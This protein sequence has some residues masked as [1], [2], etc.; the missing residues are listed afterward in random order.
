MEIYK[1]KELKVLI[2]GMG[3]AL[4]DTLGYIENRFEIFGLSDSD[5]SKAENE[6]CK[7]Y[8]FF[9]P[10]EIPVE[11]IDYIVVNS[12]YEDEIC[13]FLVN[14]IEISPEKILKKDIWQRMLFEVSYGSAN[15]DKTFYVMSK[16]I[17]KR[18][19]LLSI[20]FSFLEQ[21]DF[22]DRNGY[23]PVV[24]MQSFPSQYIE[25]EKIGIENAW[26]YYYE[27]L[28]EYTVKDVMESEN[29]ILGYDDPCYQI[30][31]EE[32]Y[33]L[34]RMAELYKKY[35]HIKSNV[36]KDLEKENKDILAVK[37]STLGVLYRGT[38]MVSLKLK[39]HPIQPSIEEL[40]NI[41]KQYMVD[42]KFSHI[43]LST[44]DIDAV[45]R[46]KEEFGQSLLYT[47]QLR[48]T[49][50]GSKWLADLQ[51]NRQSDRYLRGVEYLT[52]IELLSRCNSMVAG[53]SAGSVC[54]LI[55]NDFKYEHYELLDKGSY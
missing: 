13:D 15:S 28:S 23:I 29:V 47:N 52:T 14:E 51:N 19:G 39:K 41:V 33:D 30:N 10:K 17:R 48:Y 55:M 38:D 36:L 8:K 24:D 16:Q 53:V 27:P 50:T 44:E 32:Q 22:V 7:K 43:F 49:N 21:L 40:I 18:N 46:F 31:V 1:I 37:E 5:M 12:V 42:Y 35:I 45:E 26:E 3:K 54:A 6:I 20:M 25:D 4:E 9:A 2:Y 34:M 11:S